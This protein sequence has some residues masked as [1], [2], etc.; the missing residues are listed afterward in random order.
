VLI[1][2]QWPVSGGV[3]IAILVG[4]KLILS[5]VAM[6]VIARSARRLG[7]SLRGN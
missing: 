6:V 4:I 1:W 7:R 2:R 5:G 3:A